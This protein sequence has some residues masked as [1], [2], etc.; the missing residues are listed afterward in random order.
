MPESN[1]INSQV[2]TKQER[3][4][5]AIE[6]WKYCKINQSINSLNKHSYEELLEIFKKEK[7]L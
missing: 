4:D 1:H 5:F 3:D 7:G 2:Y 6:F